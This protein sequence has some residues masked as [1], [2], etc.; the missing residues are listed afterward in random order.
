MS[1]HS[2]TL[3]RSLKLF[4]VALPLLTA[5]LAAQRDIGS[6]GPGNTTI[7][8]FV[9]VDWASGSDKLDRRAGFSLGQY[10]LFISSKLTD[11]VSF[12]GETVFEFSPEA[13]SF[14]VDVERVIVSYEIDDHFRVLG[15]KVHTPI[16]YW[17]NAYHHGRA[18]QPTIERPLTFQ[19]ED[20]GGALPVHTT[21]L[22]V[23][24]RD[25]TE[26]HLGFDVLLG[27]ALGNRPIP[28]TNSTPSVTVALHSQISPALRVGVSAYR[29][30]AI[31]GTAT[32]RGDSLT[33]RLTQTIAGAFLSYIGERHEAIAEFEQVRN[34][35][36]GRRT[37]SP[38]WFVYAGIRATPNLIPYVMHDQLKL[39]ANDP[40]FAMSDNKREILGLRWEQ[41]AA[42]VMKAELRSIDNKVRGRATDAAL[43]V[44]VAF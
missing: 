16:G 36:S 9:D 35:A 31:A 30:Q 22:Q 43:Q 21:G 11:R 13:N 24:G 6:S 10:D 28:D 32:P 37:T 25:L 42:L 2:N 23:S 33:S 19:F 27:N 17:N 44:A 29:D 15:G 41:S 39:A 3:M 14:G 26:A 1:A 12:L 40:Y 38:G 5:R 7:R 4:A 20:E 8:G 18:F 34:S